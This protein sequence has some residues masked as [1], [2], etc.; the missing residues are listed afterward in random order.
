MNGSPVR[1]AAALACALTL[2]MAGCARQ[3]PASMPADSGPSSILRPAPTASTGSSG[4]PAA[5]AASAGTPASPGTASATRTP[6]RTGPAGGTSATVLFAGDLLW[7]N[8]LWFGAAEDHRRTGK[9]KE[10]DFGPMFAA[11]TPQI[12]AADL[13][14]CHSEVPFARDGGPYTGYPA[15]AAPP[16]IAGQ[17]KPMGWDLCTTSS[18]HSLDQGF[19]GLTR[20]LDDYRRAGIQTTG[21]WRTRAERDTP[22]IFTTAG[23]VKISIVGGTYG[24]NGIPLPAQAPWS[25]A[26]LD[27]ADILARARAARAAGADIVIAHMH[28]GDE[29]ATL[30]NA[31][32]K[33]VAAALTASPDID[34]VYGQHVHVVQPWTKM[35]GKWVV[36]GLGN[37]VSQHLP[38]QPRGYEGV[39][40]TM[41]FTRD[42]DGRWQVT[43]ARYMPTLMTRYSPGAPARLIHLTEAVRSGRGDLVRERTALVRTRKAVTALGATG[44]QE[45]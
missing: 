22:V 24:T 16:E 38:S 29:Y 9:G 35:N 26:M 41:T 15:F 33:K 34:M 1:M 39:V 7:H 42:A 30:P 43:G 12:R 20:T 28:A 10:F 6:T 36:Y 17:L 27:T 23:G 11:L 31:Q 5:V 32:Q 18:N 14:V 13:A 3:A 25:V 37:L 19:A 21:T 44:L 4:T 45:V 8:T 2:A 40:A